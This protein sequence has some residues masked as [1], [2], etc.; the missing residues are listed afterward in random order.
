MATSQQHVY[1][2]PGRAQ[3]PDAL[4]NDDSCPVDSRHYPRPIRSKSRASLAPGA[5]ST[6]V[7]LN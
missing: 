4:I 6:M 7:R 2:T 5:Y 1:A 3:T